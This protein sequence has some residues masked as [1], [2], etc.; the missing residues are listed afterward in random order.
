MEGGQS[1]EGLQQREGKEEW[2]SNLDILRFGD[3]L[4]MSFAAGLARVEHSELESAL[5]ERHAL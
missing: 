4:Q 2:K 1:E 5:C 3:K